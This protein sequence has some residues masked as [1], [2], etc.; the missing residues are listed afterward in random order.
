LCKEIIEGFTVICVAEAVDAYT[1]MGVVELITNRMCIPGT[2]GSSY[3]ASQFGLGVG[4][5]VF[6]GRKE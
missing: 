2:G 4:L 6:L 1:G 3:E 5:K